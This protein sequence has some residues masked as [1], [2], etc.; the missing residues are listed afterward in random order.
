SE[1]WRPMG[2]AVFGGLTFS[3]VVT[4]VLIPAIYT[5][6]GVGKI[7]RKK[8]AIERTKMNLSM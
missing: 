5:I 1:M 8:K 7:K 6:F 3:T 2:V 4:L